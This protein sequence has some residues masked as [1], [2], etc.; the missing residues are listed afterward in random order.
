MDKGLACQG[1]ANGNKPLYAREIVK[2][3][4][5]FVSLKN[6]CVCVCVCVCVYFLKGRKISPGLGDHLDALR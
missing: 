1:K 2:L 3:E 6:K 5:L 4:K